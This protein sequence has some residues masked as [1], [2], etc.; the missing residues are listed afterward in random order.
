[1]KQLKESKQEVEKNN[2]YKNKCG[3]IEEKII[4]N[5]QS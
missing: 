3:K 4:V 1:M 2:N 5:T